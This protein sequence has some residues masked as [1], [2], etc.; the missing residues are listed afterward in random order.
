MRIKYNR[1]CLEVSRLK[2]DLEYSIL[3]PDD[4]TNDN[5][6]PDEE[7]KPMTSNKPP[8]LT[9]SALSNVSILS[10]T[11]FDPIF[12]SSFKDFMKIRLYCTTLKNCAVLEKLMKCMHMY[13]V[14]TKL[15]CKPMELGGTSASS[16]SRLMQ[17]KSLQ[18]FRVETAIVLHKLWKPGESVI[19]LYHDEA[20]LKGEATESVLI[21]FDAQSIVNLP[22]HALTNTMYNGCIVRAIWHQKIPS[23]DAEMTINA[24]IKPAIDLLDTIGFQLYKACWDTVRSRMK[25]KLA[26][27]SD[28]NTTAMLTNKLVQKEFNVH[29]LVELV[30]L[31]HNLDNTLI[32]AEQRL[33]LERDDPDKRDDVLKDA[34]HLSIIELCDRIQ[35]ALMLRCD[36]DKNK[37]VLFNHYFAKSPNKQSFTN[38]HRVVGGRRQHRVV[39][40]EACMSR[41]DEIGVFST[42][43]V[44]NKSVALNPRI[45]FEYAKS[46]ILLRESLVMTALYRNF[47]EPLIWT[48]GK[49]RMRLVL[50]M[51]K[52]CLVN[53][54]RIGD[55]KMYAL[56]SLMTLNKL[57]EDMQP[58]IIANKLLTREAKVA[59]VDSSPDLPQFAG[60]GLGAFVTDISAF[61]GR[62]RA[63]FAD[64][65]VTLNDKYFD[66][67]FVLSSAQLDIVLQQFQGVCNVIHIDMTRRYAMQSKES[68]PDSSFSTNDIA[69]T[70]NATGKYHERRSPHISETAK[71]G[72]AIAD[73]NKTLWRTFDHLAE[74]EPEEFKRVLRVW[75]ACCGTFKEAKE[76][77][78]AYGAQFKKNKRFKL[79]LKLSGLNRKIPTAKAKPAKSTHKADHDEPQV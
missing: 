44:K 51:L 16:L 67:L 70:L 13:N 56:R 40:V 54:K 46:Q 63:L 52:Q 32:T 20:S 41:R 57:Y 24:A 5:T 31:M 53:M 26:T 23:K 19:T 71:A 76:R 22:P 43:N 28:Q 60:Q 18:L 36:T 3:Y 30:C 15:R 66:H 8:K 4:I 42:L 55:D 72:F 75:S 49:K 6:N 21:A 12:V 62:A 61:R 48:I 25:H 59:I 50:P 39:N 47:I 69:E 65:N 45:M 14:V 34:K 77:K 17:Y 73:V 38:Y 78:A 64:R 10:K 1:K 79:K 58:H 11:T 29:T 2:T 33:L 74:K 35:N 68:I 37:G 7:F 9:I 27:I